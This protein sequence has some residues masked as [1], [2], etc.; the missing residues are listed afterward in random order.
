MD[1]SNIREY[2]DEIENGTLSYMDKLSID[3]LREFKDRIDFLKMYD[4]IMRSRVFLG[5]NED[6]F[7]QEKKRKRIQSEFVIPCIKKERDN[8]NK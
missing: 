4:H 2:I 3:F 6:W 7:E 5:F 1:E 8:K